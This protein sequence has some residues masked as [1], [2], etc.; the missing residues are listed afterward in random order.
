VQPRY[1][2]G[3]ETDAVRARDEIGHRFAFGQSSPLIAG[4]PDLWRASPEQLHSVLRRAVHGWHAGLVDLVDHIDLTTLF[5]CQVRHLEPAEPWR[6]G[7]VTLLGDAVHAMPPTVGAGANSA[8]RDAASLATQLQRVSQ[9]GTDVADA[10]AD[11]EHDMRT[12]VFPIL[13][14]S[15][16]PHA[17][18]SGF[19]QK[20]ST[21]SDV[22]PLVVNTYRHMG[23][24][25]GNFYN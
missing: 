24:A 1:L 3:Y 15:T 12:Q 25:L 14:A 19:R 16:D 18:D 2:F 10:V 4:I 22:D 17:G 23:P 13:R 11:Y 7:R 21:P 8:L 6:S 9:G 5:R 20:S